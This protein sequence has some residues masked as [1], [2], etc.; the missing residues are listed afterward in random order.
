MADETVTAG[1]GVVYIA[2]AKL[3]FMIAGYVIYFVLP[4][5]LHSEAQWGD[6]LVVIGL[7]SVIDNVLITATIQ[8]VSKFTAQQEGRADAVKRAALQVQLVL[9]V[10]L[11]ALYL[12]GAPWIARWERD[13]SL[14][15]LYRISTGV[16]FCYAFY[17][18]FVGSLN[19]LRRFGRQAALDMTFATMRMAAILGAAALGMGVAGA[20]GGFVAAAMAIL[21][22]SALWVGLPRRVEGFPRREIWSLMGQLFVYTLALNLIMRVDLFLVKRF[23]AELSGAP[24]EEAAKVA[25]AY[26][27]YYG[28]AQSLAFIPYQAILAVAFVIFPLVSRS[29]FE[30]DLQTTQ[31]Y[32]RQ[33]LRLSLL[34]VAGVAVVFMA[35]P[36]AVINVV[37]QSKYRIGGPALRVLS[38]GMIC[39][40]MFTIINTILNGAG[41]TGQAIISGVVTLAAASAANYVLIPRA[42]TLESA[43]LTAAVATA[44]AMA[45]GMII[46]AVFT[47][48][49]FSAFIPLLSV[50]RVAIAAGVALAVGHFVP[51][52]SKLVTLA[53]CVLVLAVYFVVLI[54]LR[55]FSAEDLRRFKRVLR[56]GS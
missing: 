4:R 16:M 33:T 39:F 44:G 51:E 41:R 10:G 24:V 40:S 6:Y 32:V 7:V 23:A 56:R 47:Y 21:I 45:L 22:L 17:S 25:S 11:A 14:T 35:N 9:A 52:R 5:L 46:S 26:A 13:P 3:Y 43:L 42:A 28:T 12:G 30:N 15:N 18:V 54:V 36:E 19:G 1:R 31:A 49:D 2:V 48:K 29:T 53:E 20:I 27:G 34:F 38:L 50:V 8:A 55:E 37:Y